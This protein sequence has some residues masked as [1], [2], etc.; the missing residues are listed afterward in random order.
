MHH[1]TYPHLVQLF[2]D[3]IQR[4]FHALVLFILCSK[5]ESHKGRMD[6]SCSLMRSTIKIICTSS[7]L[8]D[9]TIISTHSVAA[10]HIFTRIERALVSEE[11]ALAGA[12]PIRMR[13]NY[14]DKTTTSR[15][16]PEIDI[17]KLSARP[18]A[19]ST[20]IHRHTQHHHQFH[21]RITNIIIVYTL[22]IY[23]HINTPGR[24]GSHYHHH[25]HIY[26]Y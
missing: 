10:K 25:T 19:P 20:L 12:V 23:I 7:S 8:F 18:I 13:S 6:R 16:R 22:Y 2:H 11:S 26:I 17:T 3:G 4:F 14:V 9:S 15:G 5:G 24:R 1:S 21:T